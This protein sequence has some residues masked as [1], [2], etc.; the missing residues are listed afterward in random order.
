[1]DVPALVLVAL[2]LSMDSFAISVTNGLTIHRIRFTQGLVIALVLALFQGLMPLAGWA[3][4]LG[5]QSVIKTA[6]HWIAFVLLS[7]I[8]GKM[9]LQGLHPRPDKSAGSIHFTLL[10]GQGLATSIDALVVGIT[11]AY[12]KLSIVTAAAIIGGITFLASMTGSFLG[13]TFSEKVRFRPELAGGIIL[14]G[15]GLK[16]LIEHLRS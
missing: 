11:F 1:M 9:I 5:I 2:A 7:V 13:K 10:L 4:G 8:G 12:M 6:D 3:A 14:I 15:L 16:I